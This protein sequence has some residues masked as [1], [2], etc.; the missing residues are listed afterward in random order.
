MLKKIHKSI[1][2]NREQIKAKKNRRLHWDWLFT[3]TQIVLLNINHL[4]INVF[5]NIKQLL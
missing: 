1:I 2:Y 5:T 4:S 3:D